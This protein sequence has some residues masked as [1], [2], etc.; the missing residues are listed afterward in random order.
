M[1]ALLTTM[2]TTL[3]TIMLTAALTAGSSAAPAVAAPSAPSAAS[4]SSRASTAP[5]TVQPRRAPRTRPLRVIGHRGHPGREVTENTLA[6]FARAVRGG[7]RGV[8]LDVRLTAEGRYVVMHDDA[9]ARTTTCQGASVSGSTL[10]WIQAHCRGRVR[11][12]RIPSLADAA[13][14]FRRHQGVR[15]VVELKDGPWNPTRL[16]GVRAVLR[17]HA[18]LGRTRVLSGNLDLLRRAEQAA[19]ELRTHAQADSA[20]E[21]RWFRQALPALSGVHLHARDASR[22][23]VRTLRRSSWT[24]YGRNTSSGADWTRLRRAGV[25]GIVTDAVRRLARRA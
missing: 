10:R 8:E 3:L 22:A 14:W 7:A 19:P 2:V 21:A 16:Q 17:S 20:A 18:V 5:V 25:D 23:L 4:A 13:R 12:E 24:V 1:K 6:S 9:L 15:P 11:G